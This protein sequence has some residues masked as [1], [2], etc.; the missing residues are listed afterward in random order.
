M[1]AKRSEVYSLRLKSDA[2]AR[3]VALAESQGLTVSHVVRDMVLPRCPPAARGGAI[4]RYH[5]DQLGP[6]PLR[7]Q[8][9]A[10][11]R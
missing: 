5:I 1:E 6:D 4:Q 7:L 8:N 10:L 11:K 2:R 9:G 3:L